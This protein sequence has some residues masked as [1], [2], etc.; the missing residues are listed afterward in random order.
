MPEGTR[1][2]ITYWARLGGPCTIPQFKRVMLARD[3]PPGDR[4]RQGY[5]C[6]LALCVY[7]MK[8]DDTKFRSISEKM[9]KLL[10]AFIPYIPEFAYCIAYEGDRI[11][12]ACPRGQ[13]MLTMYQ[14]PKTFEANNPGI[15]WIKVKFPNTESEMRAD[16]YENV[17]HKGK[18]K[19][20]SEEADRTETGY[21]L[22]L[23]GNKLWNDMMR[24]ETKVDV[25]EVEEELDEDEETDA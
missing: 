21:I 22:G 25:E 8:Q 7:V 19:T 15:E 17:L 14:L 18:N 11:K 3:I 1:S 24:K 16:F 4:R 20:Y 9:E 13:R 10:D 23:N 12:V 6:G 2:G 5:I